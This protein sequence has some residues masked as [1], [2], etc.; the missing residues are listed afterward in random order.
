V[1]SLARR[2]VLI[3]I[4]HMHPDSVA[5]SVRIQDET[6]VDP[7]CKFPLIASHAGFYCGRQK[8]MFDR[9]AVLEI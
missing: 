7:D 4:S 6:G 1:R 3:D 8:F 5:E 2:P 9:S